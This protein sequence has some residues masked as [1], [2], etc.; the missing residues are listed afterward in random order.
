MFNIV[1]RS[2]CLQEELCDAA[3]VQKKRCNFYLTEGASEIFHPKGL[4]QFCMYK[5]GVFELE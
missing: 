2:T 4:C 3:R 5:R 1:P